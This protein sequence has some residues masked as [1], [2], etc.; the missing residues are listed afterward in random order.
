MKVRGIAKYLVLSLLNAINLVHFVKAKPCFLSQNF[1]ITFKFI[2]CMVGGEGHTHVH[3]LMTSKEE[4]NKSYYI[5]AMVIGK[6]IRYKCL[7]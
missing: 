5:I 2:C 1:A 7:V 3:G 6:L 4:S